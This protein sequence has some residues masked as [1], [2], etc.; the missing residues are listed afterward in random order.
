M[1]DI[2][3]GFDRLQPFFDGELGN[4]LRVS[5]Q[6][7]NAALAVLDTRLA[8]VDRTLSA[9]RAFATGRQF[10]GDIGLLV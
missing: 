5:L 9:S 1:T 3:E 6:V 8:T 4:R 7:I 10:L 2:R